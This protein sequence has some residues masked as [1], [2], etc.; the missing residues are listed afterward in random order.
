MRPAIFLSLLLSGVASAQTVSAPTLT[1]A[2]NFR[3]LGGI[4]TSDGHVVRRGRIYRSG[5][6]SH[7]T[8]SD[9][10]ALA[11]LHIHY[12]FDLRT[13]A[14]RASAPTHW[15]AAQPGD[16]PTLMP[17]SVGF[18]ATEAPS[19]SMRKL[20]AN[21]TSPDQVKDG[22]KAITVQIALDGAREI[23]TILRDLATGDEPAIVH[24]TA[25]KDRT[26]IVTA[27]LL[28]VLGVPHATVEAD[29]LR[30]NDAVPAQMARLQA[31]A[32]SSAKTNPPSPLASLPPASV[33]VLMGVDPG[34]LAAAF[35][36]IDARYG[37]FDN[38]VTQ[39]LRLSP[40]DIQKLRDRLL[41]P[42]R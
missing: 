37:S 30:S 7:L 40:T 27:V 12:V 13:D 20:F 22:M 41:D 36:A 35:A 33:Q 32:V 1:G 18:P 3:D 28:R 4:R 5:E 29:Y 25:G 2:L 6:L 39:S 15:I 31:A 38:Y 8:S 24:C 21:G 11:P 26:G 17:I 16:Q 42:P 10:D 19:S 34:Y 9:F 23:G 14:E